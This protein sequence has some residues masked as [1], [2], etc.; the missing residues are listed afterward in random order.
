MADIGFNGVSLIGRLTQN[1]ALQ[2]TQTGK[3]MCK[4]TL[5]V[6]R[7]GK[8]DEGADFIR[9]AAFNDTAKNLVTYISKGMRIFVEG[10]I[11][12]GSYQNRNDEKVYTT[13]V[14]CKR[15]LFLENKQHPTN[16]SNNYPQNYQKGYNIPYESDDQYSTQS[17]EFPD[18]SE[19]PILDISSDDLP[20]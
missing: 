17:S 6:N 1:P 20:F 10:S 5:A 14:I 7:M 16:T 2:T 8:N 12:T 19:G 11:R 13:E 9:C 18:Y 4:F 15:I 3:S